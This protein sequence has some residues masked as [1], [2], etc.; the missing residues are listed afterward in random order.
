M[1]EGKIVSLPDNFIDDSIADISRNRK[2]KFNEMFAEILGS[3]PLMRYMFVMT[4]DRY[5]IENKRLIVKSGGIYSDSAGIFYY[6]RLHG[7][8]T[9]I[10]SFS[11]LYYWQLSEIHF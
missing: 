4:R 6:L 9:L 2:V 10:Y 1:R 5:L 8:R 3:D 7:D 11:S